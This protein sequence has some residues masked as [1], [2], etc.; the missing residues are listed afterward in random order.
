MNPIF[1]RFDFSYTD[2]EHFWDR[3]GQLAFELRK[4]MPGLRVNRSGADQRDLIDD[5]AK[6]ELFFGITA[7]SIS[8]TAADDEEF[9]ALAAGFLRELATTFEVQLLHGFT[10]RYVVAR[11][12]ATREEAEAL[13]GPMV[14]KEGQEKLKSLAPDGQPQAFQA[15]FRRGPIDVTARFALLDLASDSAAPAELHPHLGAMIEV[16]GREPISIAEFDAEAFMK[17]VATKQMDEILSRLAPHLHE[18]TNPP[19]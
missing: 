13:F 11:R 5:Q 3:S 18:P 19:S 9:I 8:S 15:E 4:A 16:R 2:G 7:A 10:F 12:C 17:N 14:G 1:Q 6:R